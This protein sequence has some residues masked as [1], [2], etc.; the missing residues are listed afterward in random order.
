[1]KKNALLISAI[2]ILLAAVIG[3]IVW[4]SVRGNDK[5][6]AET[7]N[8]FQSVYSPQTTEEPKKTIDVVGP[9][10]EG[11]WGPID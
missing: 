6:D 2:A 1:M 7:E 8:P 11:G 3:L 9:N 10:E 5:P 4:L